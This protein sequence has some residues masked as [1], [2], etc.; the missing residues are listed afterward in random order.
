MNIVNKQ[1]PDKLAVTYYHRK[2]YDSYFSIERLFVNVRKGMP[3]GVECRVHVSPRF[4]RGL[5]PRLANL[6]EAARHA[7]IDRGPP[8]G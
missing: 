7:R 2:P 1:K 8:R 5:L 6:R 3:A 4:S